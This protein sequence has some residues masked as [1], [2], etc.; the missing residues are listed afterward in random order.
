MRTLVRFALVV[1]VVLLIARAGRWGLDILVAYDVSTETPQGRR[2][3]RKVAEAC[4]AYGQRVQKSVFECSLT[5][6]QFEALRHRLLSCIEEQEDS[7]RIYRLPHRRDR[8]LWSYGIQHEVD[9]KGP[10][11]I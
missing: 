1:L 8:Y 5:D 9:Y 7:L 2:R 6:L 4:L 10:L 11:I 3:L